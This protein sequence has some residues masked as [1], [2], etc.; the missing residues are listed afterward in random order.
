M[1]LAE[2][3]STSPHSDNDSDSSLIT[4]YLSDPNSKEGAEAFNSLLAK[5]RKSFLRL[6]MHIGLQREDAEDYCQEAMLTMWQNIHQLRDIHSFRSWTYAIITRRG[7][8]RRQVISNRRRICDT[9]LYFIDEQSLIAPDCP[10]LEEMVREE[11]IAALNSAVH[12][13][14]EPHQKTLDL[15]MDGLSNKEVADRLGCSPGTTKSRTHYA[16]VKLAE[17]FNIE[18]GGAGS[19]CISGW[20]D[21]TPDDLDIDNLLS[22]PPSDDRS[23][24]A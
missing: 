9:G 1:A 19:G 16:R 24:A 22:A 11:I 20:H 12:A 10:S 15:L 2:A 13:L 17:M 23:R 5:H 6:A 7:A 14:P 8:R 21:V 18:P 3:K 4:K